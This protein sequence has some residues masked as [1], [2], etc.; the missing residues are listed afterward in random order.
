MRVWQPK[1]QYN[2]AKEASAI[3]P[4]QQFSVR[5]LPFSAKPLHAYVEFGCMSSKDKILISGQVA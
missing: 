4:Q 2:T 5:L 3:L 1:I